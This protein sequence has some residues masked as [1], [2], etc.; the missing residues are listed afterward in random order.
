MYKLK[1]KLNEKHWIQKKVNHVTYNVFVPSAQGVLVQVDDTVVAFYYIIVHLV[2]M[3]Q[4]KIVLK[5]RNYGI[6]VFK[7][8][9]KKPENLHLHILLY[10][11]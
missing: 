5:Y 4:Y 7:V 2:I 11:K 9:H 8:I 10:Q 3:L 6:W 1:I